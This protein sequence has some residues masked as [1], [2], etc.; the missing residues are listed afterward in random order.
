MKTSVINICECSG[1]A[2]TNL[3]TSFKLCDFDRP[4]VFYTSG[5]VQD[6]GKKMSSKVLMRFRR[7]NT[8]IS[9]C[10]GVATC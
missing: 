1:E 10:S 4:Y 2:K 9:K 8:A 3:L 6:P 5:N 7:Y